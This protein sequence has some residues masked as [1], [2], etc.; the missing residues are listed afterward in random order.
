[1]LPHKYSHL[2]LGVIVLTL[3]IVN[4]IHELKQMCL[5]TSEHH[6]VKS[7][8][9]KKRKFVETTDHKIIARS[10]QDRGQPK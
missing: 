5:Q 8:K 4:N 6:T 7:K 1:M 10:H 9:K 2:E 3:K